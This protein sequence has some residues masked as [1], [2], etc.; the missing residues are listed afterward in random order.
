MKIHT[1]L[2]RKAPKVRK[3]WA[4]FGVLPLLFLTPASAQSL[5]GVW[6][7]TYTNPDGLRGFTFLRFN[8]DGSMQKQIGWSDP[9]GQ[10]SGTARCQGTYQFNGQM[11]AIQLTACRMCSASGCESR[12]GYFPGPPANVTFIDDYTINIGGDVYHRQ[13]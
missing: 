11:A 2:L 10:G 3:L 13:Q 7:G 5:V 1:S 8:A 6:S 4:C 9:R 12:Q